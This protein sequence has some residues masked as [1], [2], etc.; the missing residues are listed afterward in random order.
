[1]KNVTLKSIIAV[2]GVCTISQISLSAFAEEKEYESNAVVE[3]VPDS[4]PTDPVDPENPDPNKPVF[5]WDP[6]TP[7]NRPNPGTD[8]PLSL[9]Y[10]SSI[11]FG[12]NK[13]TNKDE[14]Y[15]ADA[16][17]L[18]N[19]SNT[20]KDES[21]ARPNYV[22]VTD[23]RGT[24]AGWTLLVK[25]EEQLNNVKTLN[26]EL[27]GAEIRFTEGQAVSAT[28]GVTA[29]KTQDMNLA[30][31]VASLVMSAS[32]NAGAGT[33]VD[34]FGVIEEMNINGVNTLKNKAIT[35]SVPGKTPKDAV[36][37]RTKLVWILSDA[38]TA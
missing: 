5:P 14:V 28:E 16:Q 17:Y 13:I 26:K 15:Y 31:G 23:K 2:A 12:K 8:G 7:G 34:R 35:L 38:P 36:Q 27:T 21:S 3:F 24:N 9:D 1:M 18:W 10:A 4:G 32:Q 20:E 37:Y 33:W 19:E 30:P 11:D 25:Q 29:P 6:T 22:Q